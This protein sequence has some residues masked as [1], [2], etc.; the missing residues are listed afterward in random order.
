MRDRVLSKNPDRFDVGRSV[1]HVDPGEWR[2][3]TLTMPKADGTLLTIETGKR[4]AELNVKSAK[5]GSSMFLQIEEL[6]SVGDAKI[7][8]I[9][10]CPTPLDGPGQLV[11]TIYI[12]QSAD[13]IDVSVEGVDEPIG[14]TSNHPF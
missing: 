3:V 8:D 10:R 4:L 6:G 5:I 12:H 9:A 2:V 13:V 1:G 7:V 11:T 14:T